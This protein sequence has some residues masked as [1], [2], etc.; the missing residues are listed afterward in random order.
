MRKEILISMGVFLVI[1]IIGCVAPEASETSAPSAEQI[2]PRDDF[3]CWPP[4]CSAIPDFQGKQACEDWKAGKE[5]AWPLDC[6]YFSGQPACIRLCEFET[7]PPSAE[8]P[9]SQEVKQQEIAEQQPQSSSPCDAVPLQRQ[10][11]NTPYYTGPL[12]DDHFHMPQMQKITS[13]HV[14]APVIDQDVSRRD[15]ACLFNN[16]NRVK[17]VFAFYGIP[18]NVKDKS[19]EIARDIE[20]QYPGTIN[21]FIELVSF[22]GYSVVPA[23]IEVVLRANEGLFKGYG[24]ISL[25]LPHYSGVNP[26]DPAMKELYTV[27]DKHNLIVMMHPIEG[28]QQAIEEVLRDYP[29]VQFLFHGVERLSSA[30]MFLDTFLEKYPNAHYSV[31]IDLFGEDSSG[32]PLLA[33][34][35]GKQ[36]FIN[37]FKQNWQSALNKKISFW[38]SKIEKHPDQFLW[39][40]DRGEY[41]WHYDQDINALLEEYSRAFIG[42]LDPAVQEKYAHQNAEKLLQE[43]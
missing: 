27:A 23:N 24:E 26:N 36:S 41:A 33:T 13:G 37:Q 31:D 4:S 42:Q 39:G 19:I 8:P 15:V 40:T 34:S 11:S 29:K 43:S 28:Q 3:S 17:N 1:F 22:P 20:K 32:R 2:V 25:Y 21:H 35:A 38:K 6:N 14:D 9:K 18:S 10:F 30:S 7:S 5:V 12:F 16:K